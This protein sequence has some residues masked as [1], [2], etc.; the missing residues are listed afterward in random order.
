[1]VWFHKGLEK[2][3]AEAQQK[4]VPPLPTRYTHKTALP[5]TQWSSD[6]VIDRIMKINVYVTYLFIYAVISFKEI[7]I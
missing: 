7:H 6:G 2:A 5:V 4:P 3:M 1:M